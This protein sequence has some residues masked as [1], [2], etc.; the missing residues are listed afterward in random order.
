MSMSVSYNK[1]D[2]KTLMPPND[3]YDSLCTDEYEIISCD[4]LGGGANENNDDTV[5]Q[6]TT[7]HSINVESTIPMNNL[8]N[9][10]CSTHSEAPSL[11][12]GA[13]ADNFGSEGKRQN[14]V[15][16][17]TL[18]QEETAILMGTVNTV[19]TSA[20]DST[21]VDAPSLIDSYNTLDNVI[22]S[23]SET[24]EMLEKA[25]MSLDSMNKERSESTSEFAT[26]DKREQEISSLKTR[27]AEL[28]EE[29]KALKQENLKTGQV[30]ICEQKSKE[31]ET[32]VD[33][34]AALKQQLS[35]MQKLLYDRG[36][37]VCIS[38]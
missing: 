24:R 6:W 19:Q 29:N 34:I 9:L 31:S 17:K 26:V 30:L 37:E 4:T 33:K 11:I 16:N 20:T 13:A 14:D 35:V 3:Q 25:I 7:R 22:R 10:L 38:S 2:D 32:D 18:N 28:E 8:A 27:V 5:S 15:Q 1:K 21:L 12:S 36:L 23:Q